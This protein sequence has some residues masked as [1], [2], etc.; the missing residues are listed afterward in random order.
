VTRLFCSAG[1]VGDYEHKQRLDRFIF[2]DGISIESILDETP[3]HLVF[4][5]S[6]PHYPTRRPDILDMGAKFQK[7]GYRPCYIIT[8]RDWLC[9]TRSKLNV[10]HAKVLL[11][12]RTNLVAEWMFIGQMFTG[13]T[14]RFYMVFT[15]CLFMN[16]KRTLCGL[17]EWTGLDF[18]AEL[19][20]TIFDADEKYY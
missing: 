15:S 1:C 11:E 3:E 18:P 17:K 4:R 5:R 10:G 7:A 19:A 6:I 8:L 16:P 13:F 9:N 20:H 2:E 14:G 12:A